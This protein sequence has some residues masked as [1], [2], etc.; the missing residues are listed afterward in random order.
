LSDQ[1][2]LPF[3]G[4]GDLWLH[5]A[6]DFLAAGDEPATWALLQRG[7]EWVLSTAREQAPPQFRGS[8]LHRNPTQRE[9]LLASRHLPASSTPA[10][11][12]ANHFQDRS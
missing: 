8:I 9:L 6:R 5:C 10:P 2:D 4:R 1:V 12:R 11:P 7:R 3:S